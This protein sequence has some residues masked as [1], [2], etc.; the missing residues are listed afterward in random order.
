MTHLTP[1]RLLP[2][3]LCATVAQAAEVYMVRYDPPRAYFLH[4]SVNKLGPAAAIKGQDNFLS[5][6]VTSLDNSKNIYQPDQFR[7]SLL[8]PG[9]LEVLDVAERGLV[10]QPAQLDGRPYQR[11]TLAL[12]PKKVKDRCFVGSWG[13]DEGLWYRVKEGAD[14][15]AEPQEMRLTLLHGDTE[16][17]TDTAKLRIHEAIKPGPRVAPRNFK[18]WLH[19]GPAR[20]P[21]RYDELAEMLNR[22]GINAIQVQVSGEP[23]ALEYVQEMRRRGFYIII[24]RG[25]SYESIAK[26]NMRACLEQGPDW[27]A[28]AD[29]G[30]MQVYLPHADAVL[31]DFE[32]R[33]TPDHLD[34]WLIAEFRRARN[35]PADE[36]L[37]EE[38]IRAKYLRDYIE[39][40]QQQ[41]ATCIKHWADFCR[42]FNPKIETILTEGGVLTFDPTRQIDY[43]QYQDYVTYCD[44]MNFTGVQAL[45]VVRQW[46]QRA[47][48]A[49]FTGCQN[50]ALGSHYNVF[51]NPQ[52]IMLQ[53]IS[54]ALIGQYGTSVYPGQA[55]DADNFV[56]WARVMEFMGRNEKLMFEGRPDPDNVTLSL[57]P[58]EQQEVKLGDGRVLRNTYPDWPQEAIQRAYAGENGELLLILANWHAKEQALGKLTATLPAGQWLLLDGE[59]RQVFTF[60][61][62]PLLEAKTLQTGV[63]VSC[64]PLDYRGWR[65]TKAT[66]A[67]LQAVKGYEP[68]KLEE[69]AQAAATY[70]LAGAGSDGAASTGGQELTFDDLD[71][72]GKFEYVVKSPAQQVW[73]SQ[74]GTVL[75]WKIGDT[76]LDTEGL[77]LTRDMLWLPLGERDNKG[78]DMVMR[79]ESKQITAD[80]VS[81]TFTKDV[82]LPTIGGGATV[83]VTKQLDF[84]AAPGDLTVRVRLA[85]TSIA[86]DATRFTASYRA[87]QHLKYA[88]TPE[89]LWASDGQALKQ[90]D[91]SPA[92]YT[93]PNTG[94]AAA[95]SAALFTQG[96]VTEPMSLRAFG[97][98]QPDRRLLLKITPGQ[99]EQVLQVLRWGRRKGALTGTLE[100]LYKPATLAVGQD[101]T[102]DYRVQL[103]PDVEKLDAEF[104]RPEPPG[105]PAQAAAEPRLLFHLPF[106]GSPDAVVA[107]G[108]GKA[109]VTGTPAYEPTDNGQGIVIS[110]GAKLEYLPAGNIDLQ[111]GRLAIRFKPLWEGADGKSHYLMT[112]RPEKGFVYFGK[113]ADG[114]LLMNMF[115]K[116]EKQHY[117]W[118]SIKLM[119]AETWH[120]AVCT[121]DTTKGLMLLILDGQKVAEERGEPW[122]M[123]PLNNALERCRLIIPD[124]AEAVIDDLKIW[125]RP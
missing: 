96:D 42:G 12:D 6:Y 98:L 107:A 99:P 46:M 80:G 38:T 52:T 122:E 86:P 5:L 1:L 119:R 93:I 43:A 3:L 48:R 20:R 82:P 117:G 66:P 17:Y 81:L 61:G 28:K 120:E 60:G 15:P 64:A 69:T 33:P 35:L 54:A 109:T 13:V 63:H 65:L 92:H 103:R 121:W 123:A 111:R 36:P 34:E 94:L 39:F 91:Q 70:T 23:T 84:A 115:D 10:V 97:N 49:R 40:R 8:L 78:L 71:G 32:P 124:Q 45:Q 14:I 72:D 116:N 16:C 67:A 76:T 90:W 2:L 24:Q 95:D 73:V 83:R 112:V 53:T 101:L 77:G 62:R 18:L 75:R 51:I 56:L 44:P 58:R 74:N 31:W 125:D 104:T 9:Y 37:T 55:M 100:L 118:H 41:L 105:P 79:L 85:N 108:E 114:R 26:D 4:A 7:L 19:Y 27:F 106:D 29:Q 113:L 22:A 50:V 25:G 59:H 88:E 87:H 11:V 68:V 102:Y 89:I 57:L 21:G 30:A 47:P 110:G